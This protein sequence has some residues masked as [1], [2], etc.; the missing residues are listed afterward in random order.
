MNVEKYTKVETVSELRT[1]LYGDQLRKMTRL[2]W[3]SGFCFGIPVGIFLAS[4][5]G[6]P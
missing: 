1:R 4:V 5:L 6:K 3:F 2:A